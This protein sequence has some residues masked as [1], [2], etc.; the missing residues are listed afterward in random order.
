M[1]ELEVMHEVEIKIHGFDQW[2]TAQVERV[3]AKSVTVSA[4]W[5]TAFAECLCQKRR[6]RAP[7]DE[8]C[9]AWVDALAIYSNS[10]K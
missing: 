6:D 8:P 9:N 10:W 7:I 3:G 5:I 2:V 1:E 4:L